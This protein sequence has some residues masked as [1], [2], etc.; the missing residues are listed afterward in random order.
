MSAVRMRLAILCVSFAALMAV[1]SGAFAVTQTTH[2]GNMT[3]TFTFHG[4]FPTFRSLHLRIVRA[5]R[6]LYDAP[7]SSRLCPN[8]CTPGDPAPHGRSARVLDLESNGQPDVVLGL[9][10]GGA[11]CCFVYQVYRLD[12]GTLT[13]VKTEHFFGNAGAAIKDL[14]HDRHLEFVSTNDAFYYQFGSF[15]DSG[16]PVQIWRFSAGKFVDITRHFPGVIRKDAALWWRLFTHHYDAGEGL[17]APWAAD[18]DLLG[19]PA[20]VKR[21]LARQLQLG[22]LRSGLSPEIP[23][24]ARFVAALQKF[25]H[26]QGYR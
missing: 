17:I 25:L 21:T 1:P 23:S 8:P 20:Q 6:D 19:H 10:T 14:R 2:S 22:H 5:G 18:Q 12:P 15:A 16:A 26:S 11:H 13:Y 7:V 24:G 3:V 9:Y 4:K